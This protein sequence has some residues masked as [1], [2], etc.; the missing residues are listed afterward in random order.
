VR[1]ALT[2]NP[3]QMNGS[4]APEW[5]RELPMGN[6]VPAMAETATEDQHVAYVEEVSR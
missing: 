4:T 5:F 1:Y 3:A 2:E 6:G